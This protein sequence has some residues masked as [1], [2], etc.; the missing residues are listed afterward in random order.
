MKGVMAA[1]NEIDG[2]FCH[3][4]PWL[5]KKVLREEMGFT[6]AVMADG[7]AIDRLDSLTGSS[8]AS[9]AM[10]LEAGV[11]IGLWDQAFS[12]LEEAV[13]QGLVSE[14]ELDRAVLLVLEQKFALGLFEHPYLGEEEPEDFNDPAVYPQS[15]ELARQGAVLL[16]NEGLLPL[17]AAGKKI[18]LIGPNADNLYNQLGDYTPQQPEGAGVT[19]REGL[20]ELLGEQLP[21]ALG[22]PVCGEDAS[23]I[24]E[25]VEL[26]KES[27]LV[28]LA[29]GGSSS[30]FAGATFDTNGA[31][32]RPRRRCRWTAARA[33]TA[34]PCGCPA[35]RR[36]W[37]GRWPPWASRWWR[38]SSPGGP[39]PSPNWRRRPRRWCTPS[40]PAPGAAWPWP[41]CCWAR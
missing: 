41:K 36:S 8:A 24:P 1:Y 26:A 13:E 21:Y 31:A 4:N 33:S 28:I 7:C 15:L 20:R 10:A 9:G 18:A 22:C 12:H 34:P 6:G 32:V 35:A 11:D 27:D 19:L 38:W 29:L 39:T 2:V 16:K 14:K 30:R 25:A 5:L 23:G 37:C 17:Q 3:G 40:I